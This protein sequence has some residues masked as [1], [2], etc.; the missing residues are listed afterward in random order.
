MKITNRSSH[1]PT[2][3]SIEMTNSSQGVCLTRRDQSGWIA[4][5]VHRISAQNAQPQSPNKR[6]AAKQRA[7]TA[8]DDHAMKNPMKYPDTTIKPVPR[9]TIAQSARERIVNRVARL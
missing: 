3:T 7:N 2:D 8:P 5:R 4:T 1:M 6:V 9:I